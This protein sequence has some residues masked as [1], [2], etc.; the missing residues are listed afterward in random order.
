MSNEFVGSVHNLQGSVRDIAGQKQSQ[1]DIARK[2]LKCP[3]RWTSILGAIL[4]TGY[5]GGATASQVR[6]G[7]SIV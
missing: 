7:K 5:L 3:L 2:V 1:A 6:I 4:L